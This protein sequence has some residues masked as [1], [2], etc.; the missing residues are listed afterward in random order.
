LCLIAGTLLVLAGLATRSHT[1]L[2]AGV[3]TMI[4]SAVFGFDPLL[5]LV[6]NSSWVDLAI[7][8]ACA[9]ALGSVL[10]RHGVAI[11][12][13]L[14]EWFGTPKSHDREIALDD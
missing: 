2:F 4:A 5:Q 1:T 13:R 6:V 12:L 11:N 3:I 14:A 7:F 8:G 9:I 10:D